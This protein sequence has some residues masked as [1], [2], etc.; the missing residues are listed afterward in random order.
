MPVLYDAALRHDLVHIAEHTSLLGAGLVLWWALSA[1]THPLRAAL[2]SFGLGLGLTL[3]SALLV[4]SPVVLYEVPVAGAA[5][6]GTSRLDDQRL[7]GLLMWVPGGLVYLVVAVAGFVAW[8][9][10]GTAGVP[11]ESGHPTRPK[12]RPH[13][14]LAG[15]R[16]PGRRTARGHPAG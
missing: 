2:A 7:A 5:A 9:T 16:E 12:P 8:M 15:S 3:L 10:A 11:G 4:L 13:R 1:R 14:A 6:W